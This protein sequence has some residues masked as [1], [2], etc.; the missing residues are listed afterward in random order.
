MNGAARAVRHP[1]LGRI[2]SRA[3]V[4]R[5][6]YR[7][8][9]M[10]LEPGTRVRSLLQM[11]NDGTFPHRDIGEVV[12]SAGDVGGVRDS[13]RFLNEIYYHVEFVSRAVVVIMRHREVA[14]IDHV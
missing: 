8:V 11:K 1:A 9:R 6:G 3:G 13:W 14:R 2:V 10:E 4:S 12:V 5:A 7:F